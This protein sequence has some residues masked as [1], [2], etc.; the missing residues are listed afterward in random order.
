MDAARGSDLLTAPLP[1]SLGDGSAAA[2][3]WIVDVW[4]AVPACPDWRVLL[5]K[6][7]PDQGGFWQ[8]VSGGVERTDAHLRAAA[9]REIREETGYVEG[10]RLLDLGRWI[11]FTSSASGRCFV[12][13]SLGAVLPPHAGPASVALSDEH[14]E[15]RLVAFEEAKRLVKFPE[16][17]AELATLE[18]LVRRHA[19]RG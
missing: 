7:R 18:T 11:A 1:D 6:R 12:K 3:R 13:R 5:L 4:L 8:G 19:G 10:V 15:A 16:N 14:D 17:V 9:L 2:P